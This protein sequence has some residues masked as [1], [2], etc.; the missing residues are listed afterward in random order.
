MA[1]KPD[2]LKLNCQNNDAP[3]CVSC[4]REFILPV[5]AIEGAYK[6]V[7]AK[8]EILVNAAHYIYDPRCL[9]AGGARGNRVI[10]TSLDWNSFVTQLDG[11]VLDC[12]S[13]EMKEL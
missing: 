11:N 5:T 7:D 4:G 9:G 3:A 12:G 10:K 13:I 6:T 2:F 1:Q 8:V